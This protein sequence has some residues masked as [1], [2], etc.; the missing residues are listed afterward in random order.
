MRPGADRS[1]AV[2][3]SYV[4]N[5]LVLPPLLV[6]ILLNDAGASWLE[7]LRVTGVVALLMT[8]LP[9]LFLLWMVRSGRAETVEVLDRRS[10][11]L[12][13]LFGAACGGLV[14]LYASYGVFT[15]A[16]LVFSISLCLLLNTA[17][18]MLINRRWKISIHAAAVSGFVALLLTVAL[19][20][21]GGVPVYA[22]GLI[23]AV[24]VVMWARLR[25]GAHSRGEVIAGAV[26]GLV[27][28]AAELV[29][30]HAAGIW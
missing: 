24:P 28:P 27:A 16:G 14:L 7:T 21:T 9:G 13:Y 23:L 25:S 26:L 2:G 1:L 15:A 11:L 12:P 8:L 6:A 19:I 10:R 29:A 4:V 30:L 17:V 20:R 3:I 18:L 22:F 5:P